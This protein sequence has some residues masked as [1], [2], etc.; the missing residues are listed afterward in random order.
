MSTERA[1]LSPERFEALLSAAAPVFGVA[2]SP[3]VKAGLG[4]YLSQ[5]DLW[6]RKTNL[7][8]R[9]SAEDLATHTLECVLGETLIPHG[10]QV[11][12]IGSG[13][14][15]PGVPLAIARPDLGVSPL[16]PRKKR[17]E[18]LKHVSRAVPIPNCSPLEGRREDLAPGSYDV[19]T[20][21]AVG[22]IAKILGDGAFLKSRGL[23]LAWTTDAQG[24][25]GALAP[26]FDAERSF[27]VPSSRSKV[28]AVF[29][30]RA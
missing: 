24:L 6:R 9:L 21:R 3:A 13:A 15:F 11:V 7:T 4:R 30:R 29:R 16:E 23:F 17:L 19:A 14:G 5:L 28:I 12:D 26:V 25:A 1:P 27:P 2:L 20:S 8:G 18:F 22:D 10:A